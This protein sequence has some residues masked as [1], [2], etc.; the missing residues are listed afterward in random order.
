MA[1]FDFEGACDQCGRRTKRPHMA[2]PRTY[3]GRC[4]PT[5]AEAYAKALKQAG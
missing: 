4:C 3:C 2:G 1:L 5:C